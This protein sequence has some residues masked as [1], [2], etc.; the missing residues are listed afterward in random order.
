MTRNESAAI[1]LTGDDLQ[2]IRLT[3]EVIEQL[4]AGQPFDLDEFLSV[5][6]DHEQ[7]LRRLFPAIQALVGLGTDVDVADSSPSMGPVA[8]DRTL[9]DFR[10]L[11]ELGR[12]GMGVVYEA[13]QLS[14][15]R[16]VALKV[17]PF[18]AMLDKR[19]L[20]RFKNEAR[21]AAVL[22]HPH[23]V[24]VYS[25]GHDRG[26]H[27]YAMELVEGESLA[28]VIEQLT[29]ACGEASI[30]PSVDTSTNTQPIAALSTDYS[31]NRPAYYQTIARWG[32]QIAEAL[33][34]AHQRGV[35][36]RDIKPSN[37]LFDRDGKIWISDF[38]L[39]QIQDD[40]NL[41]M[42]GDVLGTLRYMSPEQAE[43]KK[44]IDHHTDIYSLGVTIYELLTLTSPF[45]GG[46]R[47]QLMR[48]VTEQQ[49]DSLRQRDPGIP[50][51]LDTIVLK[52][53]AKRP[54][55]RFAS[56]Q[57]LA[58][59]LQRYLDHKPIKARRT[60]RAQIAWR[61][62]CRNPLVAILLSTV[63]T[64]LLLL[65]IGG[66]TVAVKYARMNADNVALSQAA[67]AAREQALR[68]LYVSDIQ[69]AQAAWDEGN[70]DHV[71]ELLLRHVPQPGANGF[72]WF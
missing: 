10:I 44:Y 27:F 11:R 7:E 68:Q 21:A 66:P 19:H 67:E 71:R 4:E 5:H 24:S 36:H 55:A 42:T 45:L 1:R 14:L 62:A 26:V 49:P 32:I 43:G 30:S 38:G 13:E 61:W 23:I 37:L 41:T 28:R 2:L 6:P 18:A 20:E 29:D 22:K 16:R 35:V 3:D 63:L 69:S 12:G 39:A 54:D 17:L 51:D 48:Q 57:E 50:Q 40:H 58:D 53:M 31:R 25:V 15:G 46:N 56:A 34:Y 60:T 33:D 72:P 52:A 65:S 9:G 59:D 64:L 70:V 47:Q 8:V